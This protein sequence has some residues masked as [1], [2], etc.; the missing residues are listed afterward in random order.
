MK[1]ITI[2]VR[3]GDNEVYRNY[4]YDE[5]EGA[6]TIWKGNESWGMHINDMLDTLEKSDVKEF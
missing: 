1:T 4:S 3:I 5:T 6:I 2:T